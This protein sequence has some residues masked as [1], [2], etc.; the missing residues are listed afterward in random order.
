M[1][2]VR[3]V[4]NGNNVKDYK[5]YSYSPE[6]DKLNS[7]KV[8]CMY[9]DELGRIW[10]GTEGCGLSLYDSKIGKFISVHV[11]WNL[12]GDVI[13]SIIGSKE[14]ELWLGTNVGLV[15]LYV[16]ED[17]SKVN[18]RLYTTADGMQIMCL[19][20]M[21]RVKPKRGNCFS[22][23]PMDITAFFRTV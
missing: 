14:D 2:I 18:Y 22:E 9:K 21:W 8:M 5:I 10:A 11:Q 4:G 17:L 6:N 15:R 23:A 7:L 20:G 12:P 16:P 13:S 1:G 19:S 3:V